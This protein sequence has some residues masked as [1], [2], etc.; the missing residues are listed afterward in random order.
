M[1]INTCL[2]IYICAHKNIWVYG[3]CVICSQNHHL[4]RNFN[5]FPTR[6]KKKS[7][8]KGKQN[9]N[10]N[11]SVMFTELNDTWSIFNLYQSLKVE[12]LKTWIKPY[13]NSFTC[14]FVALLKLSMAGIIRKKK[15]GKSSKLDLKSWI[16]ILLLSF[17]F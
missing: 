16:R 9:K 4:N 6:Q 5:S 2:Q 11:I 15:T 14:N 3:S 7:Q 10:Q 13:R 8:M 17:S 12:S 1:L